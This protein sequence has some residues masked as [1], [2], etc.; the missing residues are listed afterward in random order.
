[1][2]RRLVLLLLGVMGPAV[3]LGHAFQEPPR[4]PED[5]RVKVQQAFQVFLDLSQQ[6]PDLA[7]VVQQFIRDVD[8]NLALGDFRVAQFYANKGNY[9]GALSRLKTIID[10]CPNFSRI[11]EVDQLYKTI[12]TATQAAKSPQEHVK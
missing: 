7:P 3:M 10:K 5:Y 12:S 6:Y 2:M 9:V 4:S 11:D 1:M 8:E